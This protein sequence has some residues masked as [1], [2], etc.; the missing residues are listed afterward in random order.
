MTSLPGGRL[1]D[2]AY[3]FV[4]WLADAGQSCWQILPLGPPDATGS[5]Y[6]AAS[7][8]AGSPALLAE[9]SAPV[10]SAELEAF[11][12]S[13][14]YWIGGWAAY[15]GEDAIA[16]QVRFAREWG[17]LRAYA[18]DQGV[19]LIGDLPIYVGARSADRLA[20]PELFTP[21]LVA[22]VPPDDWSATGQLWGSPIYDWKVLR[23]TGFRWWIERFRR[24]FELVDVV[25]IDHFRGLVAYW[26][27]PEGSKTAERGTWH[28]APGRELFA[29]ARAAL[30]P[31]PLIAEDLGLITEPVEELRDALGLPGM[32]VRQLAFGEGL[33]N[34]QRPTPPR[35]SCVTYTGTHD[36]PTA[37]Q[38][39]HETS[40]AE[41]ENVR[42]ACDAAGI[43]TREPHWA[44]I[45]LALR[46]ACELAIIPAQDLLG[47]GAEARMN[48]PGREEGNW[49]WRLERGQLTPE[50]AE[51][52]RTLTE[53]AKRGRS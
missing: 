39:W 14:P 7:A 6:R 38:W 10:T 31:M 47:L 52:L 4:D 44:L 30:G 3:R 26:A 49:R 36:N 27:V 45:E 48:T 46:S 37:A 19:R 42:R 24:T 20:W 40:D 29:A 25:R 28:R 17:R 23:S 8:F 13:Q 18:R 43:S 2:E 11:V 12:A 53:Q 16:A 33:K 50:L 9:P 34:P 21:G 35:A 32:V 22:G 5:P 41:R 1:G 15:A 51:R